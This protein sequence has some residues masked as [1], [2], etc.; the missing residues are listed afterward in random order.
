VTLD[1]THLD[2]EGTVAAVLEVVSRVTTPSGER[3]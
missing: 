3:P 2:F 1:S